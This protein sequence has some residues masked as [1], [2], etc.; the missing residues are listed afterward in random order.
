[1]TRP[2]N[3]PIRRAQRNSV[4]HDSHSR[5]GTDAILGVPKRLIR[6]LLTVIIACVGFIAPTDAQELPELDLEPNTV[7]YQCSFDRDTNSAQIRAALHG[8][9]ALP[10]P[11]SAYTVSVTQ[12]NTGQPL[13]S[14][15]VNVEVITQRPPLRMILLLDVTDTVPIDPV[16]SAITEDLLPNL[17][18]DDQVSL[19]TFAQEAAPRTQFYTDKN[20]L[21]NEHMLDLRPL[22]GDNRI[23]D[24]IYNAV[25]A[26]PLGVDQR[27]VIVTVTDSG[28]RFDDQR[29]V[30]EIVERANR[31]NIQLYLVGFN[32]GADVPD[33]PDFN[34]LANETGGYAWLYD[35][36]VIT[37]DGIR[38]GVGD[39][40]DDLLVTL[41]SEILVTV[42]LE[43]VEPGADNFV[44]FNVVISTNN[45][46][47]L[48][49]SIACPVEQLEHSI[50][51]T[52]DA[53]SL[54]GETVRGPVDIAV[55][56]D[57]DLSENDV[58]P[59]F[60]VN[61]DIV[62]DNGDRILR[63]NQPSV[64]PGFYTV[65][66]QLRSTT[67]EILAT[68]PRA[69]NL[70]VQG[71]VD[72]SVEDAITGSATDTINGG[73]RFQVTTDPSFELPPVEFVIAEASNPDVQRPLGNPEPFNSGV[74]LKVI[75]DMRATV[76][77]LFPDTEEENFIITARVTG[78]S[79]QD[80]Q[81]AVSN[82]F[83]V[84]VPRPEPQ[85]SAVPNV[86]LNVRVLP[87]GL[88]LIFLLLNILTFRAVG[89]S[90]VR[91]LIARPDDY[92]LPAQ[93]MQI[94]VRREGLKQ[95]HSLT[96][97]TVT[98]G[99]GSTNDINLGD[100]PNISREHGV[101]LYRRGEWYYT[102]RKR[103]A[104]ARVNGK[105]KIGYVWEELVPI[106]EIE[107]G[108]V[109]LIFHSSAQQDVSELVRTNL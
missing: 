79:E 103:R 102:N 41:D 46:E 32:S 72:L 18:V 36:L 8:A 86:A 47:T 85:P 64:Q 25:T 10:I 26:F 23:Y 108:D 65:G 68:T 21:V 80:P 13:P 76:D 5:W 14:D 39:A 61:D 60:L 58:V 67:G 51:F 83:R 104:I 92:Q 1:M 11:R 90:R 59:V 87:W 53:A 107:I 9:D 88:T 96:K 45:E 84:F 109:L 38:D 37:R 24:A 48:T 20:R 82:E 6:A 99:R 55:D 75:E 15:L 50:T 78:V 97:K 77:S 54:D 34:A 12:A 91:R 42:G 95:S 35:S 57:T 89:R 71:T 93:L 33:V 81:Q 52:G 40:L 66:A 28:R 27:Q 3:R 16:V 29:T 106:T 63:F 44:N 19:I 49:T 31:E 70:F 7:A 74:A 98:V 30:T 17:Q 4:R 22:E 2:D 94:T 105:R 56:F 69:L 100:D 62:Q 43:T 101:I 73:G